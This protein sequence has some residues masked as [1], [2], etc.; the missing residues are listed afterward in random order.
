MLEKA[1]EVVEDIEEASWLPKDIS[2]IACGFARAGEVD[3]ALKLT[4]K[5][6][7]ER[8]KL[9]ILILIILY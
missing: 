6:K 7:D 1:I 4:E 9:D 5:V 2:D 3:V 8:T